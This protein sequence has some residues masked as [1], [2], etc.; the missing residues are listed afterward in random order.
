MISFKATG[1]IPIAPDKP[2]SDH[3]PAQFGQAQALVK[4]LPRLSVAQH[5]IAGMQGTIFNTVSF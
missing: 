1:Q 3:F 5:L 4:R 2:V